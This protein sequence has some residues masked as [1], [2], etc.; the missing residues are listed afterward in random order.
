MGV[1]GHGVGIKARVERAVRVEPCETSTPD[2]KPATSAGNKNLAIPLHGEGLSAVELTRWQIEG[3]IKAAVCIQTHEVG[4][5]VVPE[6]PADEDF[7]VRLYSDGGHAIPSSRNVQT[8]HVERRIERAVSVE[9]N[10]P[11]TV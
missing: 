9:A 3:C 5:T 11:L 4:L 1:G 2:A 8:A 6:T 7:A 10:N